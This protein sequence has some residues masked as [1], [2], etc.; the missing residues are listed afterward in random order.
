[1]AVLEYRDNRVLFALVI[2]DR[3]SAYLIEVLEDHSSRIIADSFPLFVAFVR[4]PSFCSRPLFDGS[5]PPS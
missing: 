5:S 1:M 4:A 3:Y 2:S